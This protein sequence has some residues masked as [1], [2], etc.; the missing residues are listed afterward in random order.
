M[1]LVQVPAGLLQRIADKFGAGSALYLAMTRLSYDSPSPYSLPSAFASKVLDSN[2]ARVNYTV[3]AATVILSVGLTGVKVGDRIHIEG[4]ANAESTTAA[5][6]GHLF[7]LYV[8]GTL[9]AGAN[10]F[11]SLAGDGGPL[12]V[13]GAPGWVFDAVAAGTMTVE[14]RAETYDGP[15][16]GSIGG[17]AAGTWASLRVENKGP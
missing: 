15:N 4:F 2:G 16:G 1:A 3:G 6:V 14:L 8:N 5:P 12:Y 17:N 11:P 10:A 7:S 9:V 13:S